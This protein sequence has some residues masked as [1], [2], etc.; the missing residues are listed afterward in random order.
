[1]YPYF[2][3]GMRQGRDENKSIFSHNEQAV[4]REGTQITK[5]EKVAWHIS[6]ENTRDK[7]FMFFLSGDSHVGEHNKMPLINTT[8]QHAQ[9][10]C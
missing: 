1:M 2:P 6:S 8:A 9:K 3:M 5:I 4:W 10:L 7:D